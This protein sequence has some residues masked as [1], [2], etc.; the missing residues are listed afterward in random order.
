MLGGDTVRLNCRMSL[1]CALLQTPPTPGLQS[2][3]SNQDHGSKQAEAG[4]AKEGLAL[5]LAGLKDQAGHALT[6]QALTIPNLVLGLVLPAP[7]R[8]V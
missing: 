7:A 6:P 1:R 2:A 4:M 3:E 5:P 8:A